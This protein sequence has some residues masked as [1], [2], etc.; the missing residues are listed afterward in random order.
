[1]FW[2][3]HDQL[4]YRARLSTL[5][6]ILFVPVFHVVVFSN[7]TSKPFKDEQARKKHYLPT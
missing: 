1:M 7:D 3:F 4:T 5:N 6:T 2:G